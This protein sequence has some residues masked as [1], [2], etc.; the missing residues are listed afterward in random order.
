M[1]LHRTSPGAAKAFRAG[2]FA[3]VLLCSIFAGCTNYC[4]V[5]QSNPGG[6]INTNTTCQSKTGN[7]GI[8]FNASG[9]ASQSAPLRPPRI[10]VTLRGI[11]ALEETAPG[12]EAPAWQELDPQLATKPVEIELTAP[13]A[14]SCVTGPLGAAAVRAG[15]Y[16]QL[17]L[18]LA[19]N[20][21]PGRDAIA[22]LPLEESAC[23]A[24]VLSCLIVPD[25]APQPL[26]WEE[27]AE[28]VI[29]SNRIE[30]GSVR[31]SPDS[32]TRLSIAFDPV[33]SRALPAGSALRLI[34]FLSASTESC[35]SGF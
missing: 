2:L 5:F 19:T 4:V 6:T 29:A 35:P 21:S 7:V 8:T 12:D 23:G 11:D 9:V 33:S 25:S 16:R 22:A 17:R 32:S 13:R 27:P 30:G 26:T 20:A 3:A 10:F 14:N 18:R 31:V 28:I 1:R 15:I 24:N 34:P